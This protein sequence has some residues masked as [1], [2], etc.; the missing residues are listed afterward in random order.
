MPMRHPASACRSVGARDRTWPAS[1]PSWPR[2]KAQKERFLQFG[3]SEEGLAEVKGQVGAFE[4]SVI[5]GAAGRRAHTGARAE[6][7]I[8]V[9]ELMRRV[10]MLDG[11]IVLRFRDKAETLGAWES[12]R[13]VAWPVVAPTPG[14]DD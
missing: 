11:I 12:A 14:A 10:Q 4:K 5:E 6:L 8:L 7:R 3:L 2:S 9:K 13:N 1:G